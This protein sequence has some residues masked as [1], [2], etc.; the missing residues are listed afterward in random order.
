MATLLFERFLLVR[1]HAD[2]AKPHVASEF[3]GASSEKYPSDSSL[4]A[5]AMPHPIRRL[6]RMKP[7]AFVFILTGKDGKRHYGVCRQ[8]LPF[9]PSGRH[10]LGE[11]YP[12]TM[13]ILTK[14]AECLPL[15]EWFL[16]IL[17]VRRACQPKSV[18]ALLAEAQKQALRG[19][20]SVLTVPSVGGGAYDFVYRR[21][22]KMTPP[23]L[24]D[25][26]LSALFGC[27]SADLVRFLLGAILCERRIIFIS[28]RL[29]TLSM[30]I[31]ASVGLLDPIGCVAK[32]GKTITERGGGTALCA[33]PGGPPTNSPQTKAA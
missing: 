11:R 3:R 27:L 32:E 5:F 30:C 9:G 4:A 25:A 18:P 33:Q 15:F 23:G 6:A 31:H 29:D 26:S 14:Q 7:V 21:P 22:V 13:C 16:Q 20:G 8:C 10:D 2:D 17:Q 28:S 12:E 1:P 24:T 19:P